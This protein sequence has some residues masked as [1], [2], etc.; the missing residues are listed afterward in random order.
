MS[1]PISTEQEGPGGLTPAVLW[2]LVANVAI[3]FLQQ[4]VVKPEDLQAIFAFSSADVTTRWW[5]PLTYAFLH[6]GIWHI[7]FNMIALWQFG[8]RVEQLFGTARFVRFY[9]Y[10]ALGG[11]ALHFMLSRG[12]SVMLGASAAVFGVMYAFAH[13]WPRTMLLFFGV[14]PMQVRWYVTGFAA[15]SLFFAVTSGGAGVAHWAH[16][17]GFLTAMVLVRL[18]N[19]RRLG[20]W[21]DRFSPAPEL[22]EDDGIRVVPPRSMR[23]RGGGDAPDA[24]D[25]VVARSNA[26]VQRRP[27]VAAPQRPAVTAT[28][29]PMQSATEELNTL[30]DKMSLGGGHASLTEREQ[31]R[32]HELS[33]ILR[34][35]G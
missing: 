14:I 10:C 5:T 6:A 34:G 16:L 3:Y 30:L 15:L 22:P 27:P 24:A 4:T 31:E 26:I 29:A 23:P 7:L 19:A 13:A 25:D 12:N 33:L 9:I 17:G 32:L 1:S 8:P 21:Q 11:A 18:P 20:T 35:Q 28:V 2:L